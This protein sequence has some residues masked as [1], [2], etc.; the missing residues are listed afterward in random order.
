MAISDS[1]YKG[2]SI[3]A[4]NRLEI[5]YSYKIESLNLHHIVKASYNQS[6]NALNEDYHQTISGESRYGAVSRL[7]DNGETVW[8]VANI[9]GSIVYFQ[10]NLTGY[11][12]IGNKYIISQ[13]SYDDGLD[14][15]VA[16]GI[17]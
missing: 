17:V 14:M 12:L 4:I 15:D 8:H 5:L 13:L 3:I 11:T 9:G 7:G 10:Y 16:E 6:T 1:Q 2:F